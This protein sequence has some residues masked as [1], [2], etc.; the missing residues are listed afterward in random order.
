MHSA[1][2]MPPRTD[3]LVLGAGVAGL[4]AA[5]AL[6]KAGHDVIVLEARD[7]VGGRVLTLRDELPGAP[8]ELG[9]EF[10]HGAP[11]RLLAMAGEAGEP[12]YEI[13]GVRWRV[14]DGRIARL[15]DFWERLGRVM[16]RVRD[17]IPRADAPVSDVLATPALRREL[18]DER[19]LAIQFIQ[20]FHAADPRIA[21]AAKLLTDGPWDDERARR[22][23][24]MVN[25]YGSLVE[26]LAADL[27]D[28]IRFGAV[29]DR[30]AWRRGRVRVRAAGTTY[31]ARAAV[32]ALP[33]GVLQAPRGAQG[34]LSFSPAVRPLRAAAR[35]AAAGSVVRIVVETSERFWERDDLAPE[36][37]PHDRE[38][39]TFLHTD[40]PDLPVW[41]TS[42]P[43]R[44]PLLV[45]WAGG[46]LAARIGRKLPRDPRKVRAAARRLAIAA[47]ARQF[48][49]PQ[50][51]FASRVVRAWAHDWGRDPFARG[52]YSY[53]R[54][55]AGEGIAQ[56]RQPIEGTL[57]FAGEALA[58]DEMGTVHGAI[59]SGEQAAALLGRSLG[60]K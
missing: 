41:W 47:L 7:R 55:G 31:E 24:R 3:V 45:A 12:L 43:M 53:P 20:G 59:A 11:D 23:H 8:I 16:H 58:S 50:R 56:L 37:A 30:V 10:L 51:W 49:R 21:S 40:D 60:R 57:V 2:A 29:V 32:V 28:R 35:E 44:T 14:R 6:L 27:R 17:G 5:R 4:A 33:M 1:A 34:S 54:A 46:P 13:D 42:H 38:R 18:R 22:M 39:L 25:G 48:G 19:Q 52:A 26:H 15:D 9:A 36:L